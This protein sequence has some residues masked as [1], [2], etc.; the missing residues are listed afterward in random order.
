MSGFQAYSLIHSWR[1]NM[2]LSL[3]L[4][5]VI[6]MAHLGCVVVIRWDSFSKSFHSSSKT[7]HPQLGVDLLRE[8]C[9]HDLFNNV[10]KHV[11]SILFLQ[12]FMVC[13]DLMGC[14]S[15]EEDGFWVQAEKKWHFLDINQLLPLSISEFIY[16]IFYL[17]VN[18]KKY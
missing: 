14:G 13:Y 3:S 8:L 4:N 12:V 2:Y 7:D 1:N 9:Y 15:E 16:Y 11:Q 17:L 5:Y 18:N 10:I 6:V